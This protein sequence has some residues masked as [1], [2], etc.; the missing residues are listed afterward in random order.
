VLFGAV[1]MWMISRAAWPARECANARPR[2]IRGKPVEP[3]VDNVLA[4]AIE[5]PNVTR[6]M[7]AREPFGGAPGRIMP[8]PFV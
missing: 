3:E 1:G 2:A 7:A 8:G 5:A 6:D 4:V